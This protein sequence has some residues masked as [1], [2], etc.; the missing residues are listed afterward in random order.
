M[1]GFCVEQRTCP[2]I[3]ALPPRPIP[4][5][6]MAPVV[7]DTEIIVYRCPIIMLDIT[8]KVYFLVA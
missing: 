8:L 3:P 4:D 1:V 7:T 5:M 6:D 2:R